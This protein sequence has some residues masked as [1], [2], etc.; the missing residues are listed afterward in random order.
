M[1]IIMEK[2][3]NHLKS[4]DMRQGLWN[5]SVNIPLPQLLYHSPELHHQ[6]LGLLGAQPNTIKQKNNRSSSDVAIDIDNGD[7]NHG[8]V[9]NVISIDTATMGLEPKPQSLIFVVGEAQLEF[10]IDGGA[11]VSVITLEVIEK[12]GIKNLV[13]PTN[14]TLRFGDGGVEA[15]VGVVSLTMMLS[16][17]IEVK[18]SFCVTKNP[19]TPLILGID[20]I[21]GTNGVADSNNNTFSLK[22]YD[23]V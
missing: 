6:A 21:Q 12:L 9:N 10:L 20:F 11:I 1:P 23:K 14:R 3:N 18:H 17:E 4:F 22:V 7:A 13:E 15:A 19:K 2:D 8:A 5:S 16:E